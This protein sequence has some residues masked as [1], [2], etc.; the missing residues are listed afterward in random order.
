[1]NKK[2]FYFVASILILPMILAS[3]SSTN[4]SV[5]DNIQTSSSN[6]MDNKQ[7]ESSNIVSEESVENN[8]KTW[9]PR[10]HGSLKYQPRL[11]AN[12]EK[13]TPS[14]LTYMDEV[15]IDGMN[16]WILGSSTGSGYIND[17]KCKHS[18]QYLF[19]TT[20]GGVTWTKIA[21]KTKNNFSANVDDTLTSG[22]LPP[23]SEI[24]GI[25]F[26]NNTKGWIT[27]LFFNE[28]DEPQPCIYTTSDGGYTWEKQILDTQSINLP[29]NPNSISSR[30]LCFFNEKDGM[31]QLCV[32]GGES[33]WGYY[34]F[35]HDGGITWCD[36][37]YS[38][39]PGGESGPLKWSY[40]EGGR[41]KVAIGDKVWVD[42]NYGLNWTE[43][44]K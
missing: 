38:L 30:L 26:L 27:G 15:S 41:L 10:P 44:E 39:A 12:P 3:C 7:I 25:S 8:I 29:N 33:K 14:Y 31:F 23:Y 4:T 22:A 17:D 2:I 28:E 34:Y 24:D 19:K 18:E 32:G 1:M 6:I 5:M 21:S 13:D 35:T 43:S 37:Q 20:D 11:Y 36:A 16:G 40:T 42:D 9:F